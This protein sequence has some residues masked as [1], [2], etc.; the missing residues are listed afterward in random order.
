MRNVPDDWNT[1]YNRCSYC[2]KKYH[3]SEGGCDCLDEGECAGCGGICGRDELDETTLDK[4]ET[5]IYRCSDC[6]VCVDCE[7]TFVRAS[8][9]LVDGD[10]Y[11]EKCHE[12][13][14]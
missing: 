9:K 13:K 1:Y 11:C 10:L 8:L 2:G 4:E 3:A 6:G 7:E 14:R 12:D 5:P